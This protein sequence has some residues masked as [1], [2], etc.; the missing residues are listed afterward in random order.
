[1]NEIKNKVNEVNE[2]VELFQKIF[3]ENGKSQFKTYIN[4]VCDYFR[5][6]CVPFGENKIPSL[7]QIFKDGNYQFGQE[8]TKAL[9]GKITNFIYGKAKEI[10]NKDIKC[11]TSGYDILYNDIKVEIKCTYASNGK[12]NIWIGNKASTKVPIHLLISFTF[13]DETIDGLFVGIV[14]LSQCNY[15]NWKYGNSKKS[16]FSSLKIHREDS[17]KFHIIIGSKVPLK[18]NHIYQYFEVEKL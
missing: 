17:D 13:N 8:A 11:E 5:R 14:D 6:S 7:I 15:S 18:S 4:C 9:S 10:T 12:T 3:D 1:M 2:V 16:G